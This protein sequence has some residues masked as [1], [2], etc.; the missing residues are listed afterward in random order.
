MRGHRKVDRSVHICVYRPFYLFLYFFRDGVAELILNPIYLHKPAVTFRFHPSYQ[1]NATL[2]RRGTSTPGLRQ[3]SIFPLLL[4]QIF[5]MGGL[6]DLE[7]LPG[8][9]DIVGFDVPAHQS[10]PVIVVIWSTMSP[11]LKVDSLRK[12]G[13]RFPSVEYPAESF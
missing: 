7:D 5:G 9:Q 13:A 12:R 8:D 10:G 11:R 3:D 4:F 6:G 1:A 2:W